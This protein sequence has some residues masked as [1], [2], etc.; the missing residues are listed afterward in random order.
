MTKHQERGRRARGWWSDTVRASGKQASKQSSKANKHP[1]LRQGK[2]KQQGQALGHQHGPVPTRGSPAGGTTL[3]R[4]TSTT[5]ALRRMASPVCPQGQ[6][7]EASLGDS[8][9]RG[10]AVQQKQPLLGMAPW[11]GHVSRPRSSLTLSAKA[12]DARH[13]LLIVH[14]IETESGVGPSGALPGGRH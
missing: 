4:C 12:P 9:L 3:A 14:R 10:G 8:G 7:V 6:R 5:L 11:N 13:S 1:K 2:Q